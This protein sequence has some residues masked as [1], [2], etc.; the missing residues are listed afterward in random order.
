MATDDTTPSEKKSIQLRFKSLE[1]DANTWPCP[2]DL[3]GRHAE[4]E[5]LSPVLLN[6][7]SP[8]VFAID[9][10][11][12]GGKTTFF[13]LWQCYLSYE[14]KVSLYLNA[15]ES[16][17]AE[18][19]LLP[20]LSV[21]DRWL[22]DQSNTPAVRNA[23]EKAK[24]YAPSIIKSTAV[25]ATKAAT[26]GALDLDKE[27][28][29]LASELAG[30]SVGSLVE[31]F[32]IKQ[33][34]LERFKV[35]LSK[36]LDA[37]PDGQENLIL[38]VDELDRCKP[39]YAIEVLERI[40]HLFDVDRLVFV[41]A[42]NRDQLSKSFQ[43]VYGSAFDGSHYLRR[44]ID[45]DYHLNL[46]DVEAYINARIRQPDILDY[47]KSRN[48]ERDDYEYG[49][50]VLNFLALRFKF[51]LRDIDQL[52]VRLRLILRSIPKNHLLDIPLL[53]PLMVLRQ[54]N[55]NL[56]HRYT[57]NASCANEV[58]EFILDG[59][60]GKVALNH[61]MAV[62]VG[63]LIAAARDP[64]EQVP[65]EH[66]ITPWRNWLIQMPEKDPQEAVVRTV[67][68]FASDARAFRGRSEMQKL[69]SSRIELVNKMDVS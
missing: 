54:E 31:S 52:V 60:I 49:A 2:Q 43:G 59:P 7:Q 25:A 30:G 62:V 42:I 19:P 1:F 46:V 29:K 34:S 38:F 28:E 37:L 39:T 10:P 8:L 64:Y 68:E 3:L 9:A 45:L 17:F 58:A 15:W 53:I 51:T 36:A 6:A 66:L 41:L 16:D 26:F 65:V 23:W 27:Y 24:T 21:L 18:D 55:P 22:S 33:K 35:Q 44:F 56:F 61:Q 50:K 40:K 12:G 69:A 32:N 5:N 11:W 13:R 67:V 47:F 57:A 4:I 63:Y 48:S 14:N 20:M